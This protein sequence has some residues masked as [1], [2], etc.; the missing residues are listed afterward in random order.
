MPA[1]EKCTGGDKEHLDEGAH[2]TIRANYGNTMRLDAA[3]AV[4]WVAS[5]RLSNDR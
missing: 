4:L 1:P 5:C 3:D 2:L